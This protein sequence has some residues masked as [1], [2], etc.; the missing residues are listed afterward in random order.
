MIAAT[1]HD[2]YRALKKRR[3]RVSPCHATR[4]SSLGHHC[5]RFL[6]YERTAWERRLPHDEE[7]QALFDLGNNLE[8]YVLRELEASGV[9]VLQRARDYVDRRFDLTG[10]LDAKLEIE[11]VEKP[12]PAEVKGLNPYTAKSIARVE[13]IR[14]HKQVWV[15][16]YY[17]QLQAYLF[18][19]NADLG[20]FVIFNKLTG[21]VSFVECPLDYAYAESLL[22]K[23]ERVKAHVAA[24]TLP[25][26]NQTHECQRCPFVHLCL[27]DVQ[28]GPGVEVLDSAELEA[29]LKRRAELKAQR[30]EYE[31]VDEALKYALPRK[32]ELLVGEWAI[33]GVEIQPKG[34][35]PYW[36]FDIQKTKASPQ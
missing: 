30:D 1:L 3:I 22:Q 18:L 17:A 14:D 26:R 25:D 8:D 5:E 23:A 24:G 7:T 20:V 2:A 10:H 31:E 12:I 13:D 19:D 36:K 9:R 35:K 33:R 11:G 4:A 27:P 28:F 6:V 16:K 21:L 34:K 15:R 32:P 29:L